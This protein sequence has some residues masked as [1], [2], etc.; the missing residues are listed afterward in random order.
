MPATDGNPCYRIQATAI[1]TGATD[2]IAASEWSDV[3]KV[4]EDGEDG[5][6]GNDGNDGRGIASTLIEYRA[7]SSGTSIPTSGWSTSI[8]SVSAGYYLWT[9]TTIT[10]TD[11]TTSVS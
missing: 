5:N 4:L 9:R 7:Y 8:P 6:D 10:Y 11:N 3:V 2:S 1:S